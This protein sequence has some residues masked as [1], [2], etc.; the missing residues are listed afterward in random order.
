MRR[1]LSS[2]GPA[3]LLDFCKWSGIPAAEASAVWADIRPELVE[4]SLGSGPGWLLRRDRAALERAALGAPTLRLLPA[5]DSFLL[6]HAEKGHLVED[7]YY[8]KVYRSQGWIS[9]VV[10]H[11]GRVIDTWAHDRSAKRL[12]VEVR[13]FE[14]PSRAIR[15]AI[16]A[17]TASLG[18]FLE[19]SWQVKYARR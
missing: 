2:F 16:E 8:K 6:G 19:T 5:F 17:E 12:S 14:K 3:T 4:V 15:A 1:Y 9:P 11:D 13:P 7:S 10:L 18:D